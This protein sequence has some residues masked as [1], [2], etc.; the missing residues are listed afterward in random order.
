VSEWIEC[1]FAQEYPPSDQMRW[2]WVGNPHTV[3]AVLSQHCQFCPVPALVRFVC[4]FASIRGFWRTLLTVAYS[5][6]VG[7]GPVR[8]DVED[9]LDTALAALEGAKAGREEAAPCDAKG[10]GAASKS[11]Q[12]SKP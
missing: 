3:C 2:C 10:S 8:Y 4:G 12:E 9:G 7:T 6:G 5:R 11:K 1:E